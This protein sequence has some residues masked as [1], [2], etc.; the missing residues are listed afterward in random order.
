ML[1]CQGITNE[2]RS[3]AEVAMFKDLKPSSITGYVNEK[4]AILTTWCGDTLGT[5]QFGKQYRNN[6]GDMRQSIRVKG[7]N[8]I[9]YSGTYFKSAGDYAR[10]KQCKTPIR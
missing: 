6:M 5:I 1:N 7:I 4:H 2:E 3:R 9:T 10:L 8:G